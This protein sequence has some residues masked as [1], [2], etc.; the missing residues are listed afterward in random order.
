[1]LKAS[2][3]VRKTRAELIKNVDADY[4]GYLDDDDGLLVPLEAVSHILR[5]TLLYCRRLKLNHLHRQGSITRRK[6]LS[7][8][9]NLLTMMMTTT[10]TE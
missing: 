4:Y 5:F 9:R 8:P 10:F 1:M 2:K 6:E 3:E 7:R